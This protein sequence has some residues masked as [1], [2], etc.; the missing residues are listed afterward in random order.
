MN[1]D[2][3]KSLLV[4]YDQ[5]RNLAISK[6]NQ[7]KYELYDKIKG[8]E[9]IDNEINTLSIQSI[10]SIL[11]TMDNEKKESSIIER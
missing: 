10:K 9:Q 3:L 6:A 11:T 4:K 8:L 2:N 7:K 5:K 1:T